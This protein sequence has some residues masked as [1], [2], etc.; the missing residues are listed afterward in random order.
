MH[1]LGGANS[2]CKPV[3]IFS[4]P[5]PIGTQNLNLLD[6]DCAF[7]FT[8][9]QGSASVMREHLERLL[10]HTRLKS[11]QWVNL[12]R[13]RVEFATLSGPGRKYGDVCG[14]E[15][16][17]QA[18]RERRA[19]PARGSVRSEQRRL[20][21]KEPPPKGLRRIWPGASLLVGHSPTLGD[22]PSSRLA[23]GQIG[24]NKRH[25]IYALDH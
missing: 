15:F 25:R 14:E 6:Q 8:T 3:E 12:N 17:A 10:R 1:F 5:R 21:R 7:A 19:Y 9:K 20:G 11:I 24:R 18:R 16:S 13:H 2:V 4:G 23:P 22:A